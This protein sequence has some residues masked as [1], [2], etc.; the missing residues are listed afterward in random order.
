M[1]PT[2]GGLLAFAV[3]AL[4]A[5]AKSILEPLPKFADLSKEFSA[6]LRDSELR[7]HSQGTQEALV[8]FFLLDLCP[9]HAAPQG[10][11]E[12]PLFP[13][14]PLCCSRK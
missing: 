14:G 12:A 10:T 3:L 4:A 7:S 1:T 6:G 13:S 8:C 5:L 9:A 2:D 11:Q